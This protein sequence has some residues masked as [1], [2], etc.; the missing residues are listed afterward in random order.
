MTAGR[1]G[2]LW[3]RAKVLSKIH[4]RLQTAGPLS[5][6]PEKQH[7]HQTHQGYLNKLRVGVRVIAGGS[8]LTGL[9]NDSRA[10][11]QAA[12]AE[13][14]IRSGKVVAEVTEEDAGNLE[15]WQQGDVTMYSKENLTRRLA[16]RRDPRVVA[17]L[18][19]FWEAAQ[20]SVQSDG[21]KA[22]DALPFEGYA[23]MMNRICTHIHASAPSPSHAHAPLVAPEMHACAC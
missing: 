14:L 17:A 9:L 19:T 7:L 1:R 8:A 22:A 16:L 10:N 23:V 11:A 5:V 21:D 2:E 20:R 6:A 18:Q 13:Y 4:I 12:E 15:S 3:K